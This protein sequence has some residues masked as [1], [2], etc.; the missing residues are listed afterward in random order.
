MKSGFF[1]YFLLKTV[2]FQG[3]GGKTLKV[4][5]TNEDEWFVWKFLSSEHC[6]RGS[7]RSV[8][9]EAFFRHC[10]LPMPHATFLCFRWVIV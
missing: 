2:I 1:E 8:S 4:K 5:L 10:Q 6:L 9:S 3:S 7:G